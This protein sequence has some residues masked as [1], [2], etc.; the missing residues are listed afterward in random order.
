MTN[1][2]LD[3]LALVLSSRDISIKEFQKDYQEARENTSSK[4]GNKSYPKFEK[5]YAPFFDGSRRNLSNFYSFSGSYRRSINTDTLD[6]DLFIRKS[7]LEFRQIA[8]RDQDYLSENDLTMDE[9]IG[10]ISV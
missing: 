6:K 1:K 10:S 5:K 2:F 4:E 8:L 3:D 9:L 7:Q